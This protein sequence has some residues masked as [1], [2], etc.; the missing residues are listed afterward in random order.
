MLD[1]GHFTRTIKWLN[2]SC[3][4]KARI[5]AVQAY[6]Q[7]TKK[8]KYTYY[9]SRMFRMFAE[10]FEDTLSKTTIFSI[11]TRYDSHLSTI[12]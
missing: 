2:D 5:T 9:S 11:F 7:K 10:T 4:M 1:A 12:Y 6:S 8:Y 3:L